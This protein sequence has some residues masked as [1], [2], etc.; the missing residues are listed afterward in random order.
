MRSDH[1]ASSVVA[2]SNVRDKVASICIW[3]DIGIRKTYTGLL[4]G[5][6]NYTKRYINPRCVK[7]ENFKRHVDQY[8][9][10]GG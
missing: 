3:S 4:L 7:R 5:R 10:S 9:S 6:N 1:E 8:E 2:L